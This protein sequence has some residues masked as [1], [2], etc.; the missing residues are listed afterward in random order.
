MRFITLRFWR[1]H[2]LPGPMMRLLGG[3]ER[4]RER[5]AWGSTSTGSRVGC[6]GFGWFVLYG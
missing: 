6:L 2:G 5:R 1:R 3:R 4:K